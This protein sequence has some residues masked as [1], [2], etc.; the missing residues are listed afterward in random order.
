M[1]LPANLSVCSCVGVVRQF[2][3]F[4]REIDVGIY[5]SHFILGGKF[6]DVLMD[7]NACISKY[8]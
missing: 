4:G 5:I 6:E 2:F 8:L 7:Q 1:N 3:R